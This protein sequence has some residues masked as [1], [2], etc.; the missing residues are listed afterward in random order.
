MRLPGAAHSGRHGVLKFTLAH[1]SLLQQGCWTQHSEELG[2]VDTGG[3]PADEA[4]EGRQE[5][6]VKDELRRERG[7]G[8]GGR[9]GLGK[10][11]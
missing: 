6:G 7:R 2:L 3:E 9:G 10:E 8:Q 5:L 4:G 1:A 11:G